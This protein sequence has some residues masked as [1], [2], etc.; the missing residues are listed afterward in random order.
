[1]T[2]SLLLI[3]LWHVFFFPTIFTL[4][5][6]LVHITEKQQVLTWDFDVLR[7]DVQFALLYSRKA[8][9]VHREPIGPSAMHGSTNTVVIDKTM[10]IGID[11]RVVESPLV[12]KAGESIQVS[13]NLIIV[14]LFQ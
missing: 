2:L 12:C 7:G 3:H 14:F 13:E 8:L 11:Y 10:T 1:M 5:Q 4:H 6:V 9:P